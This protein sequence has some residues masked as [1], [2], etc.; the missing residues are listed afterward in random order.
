MISEPGNQKKK[1]K[2]KKTRKKNVTTELM[3]LECRGCVFEPIIG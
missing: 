1:E 2:K 3:K